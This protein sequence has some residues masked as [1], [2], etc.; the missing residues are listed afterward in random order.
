MVDIQPAAAEIRRGKK[1]EEQE[2]RKKPQGKN[3]MAPLLHRAAITTITF[4]KNLTK[5]YRL[6]CKICINSSLWNCNAVW[7]HPAFLQT[8]LGRS[9]AK[10]LRQSLTTSML[11]VLK[12]FIQRRLYIS[13]LHFQPFNCDPSF[14]SPK[15]HP[16]IFFVFRFSVLHVQLIRHCFRLSWHGSETKHMIARTGRR[17]LWIWTAL[18]IQRQ[19]VFFHSFTT[20]WYLRVDKTIKQRSRLSFNIK[21]IMSCRLCDVY[22]IEIWIYYK[23]FNSRLK[24]FKKI[25]NLTSGLPDIWYHTRLVVDCSLR[26]F[27]MFRNLN[28]ERAKKFDRS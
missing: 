3:I 4:Y 22:Y 16:L 10:Q 20:L 11:P 7:T 24:M 21:H 26:L 5:Y 1:I 17:T 9:I 2:D 15:F 28:R 13:A 6:L 25:F 19:S 12:S 23:I 27:G 8:Q 18:I 14:C